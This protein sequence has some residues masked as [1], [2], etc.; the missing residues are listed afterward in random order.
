MDGDRISEKGFSDYIP[1]KKHLF[2][3]YYIIITATNDLGE[4]HSL[5]HCLGAHDYFQ[6]SSLSASDANMFLWSLLDIVLF[7]KDKNNNNK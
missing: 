5:F 1:R 7:N 6:A 2:S 3:K 4:I